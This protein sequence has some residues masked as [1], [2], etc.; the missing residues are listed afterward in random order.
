[1][2]FLLNQQK[3]PSIAAI[4]QITAGAAPLA[5][6][7]ATATAAF[8]QF[9]VLKQKTPL[10]QD[11]DI[12][13][14]EKQPP[15]VVG[16]TATCPYGISACWGSA[17]ESL[18]HMHGVRLVRP[19]PNAQDSTAFVYL[20]HE[21][22]PDLDS[23]PAQFATLSNGSHIFRGVE[24]TVTGS[25]EARAGYGLVMDGNDTRPPLLLQ[26]IEPA[27]KIQWDVTA[28]APKPL[29]PLEQGAYAGLLEE[30]KG[31]SLDATVTGP[32]R[33]DDGR[34]YILEVRQFSVP[35]AEKSN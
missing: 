34:G 4:I 25:I 16:V 26:P 24:V 28:G 14:A 10:E 21:G 23:W 2:L 8:A 3:V 30:V 35:V 5:L 20:A 27:D 18:T 7:P 13:A 31:G 1:M 29:D 32:L 11:A 17:Y 9:Q 15:V 33:K 22:L 6:A 19:V 12:Q